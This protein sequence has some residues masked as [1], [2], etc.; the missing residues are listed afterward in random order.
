M[1]VQHR[2]GKVPIL[3][4]KWTI[5]GRYIS[6]DLHEHKVKLINDNARRLGL[7][8]IKTQTMDSQAMLREQFRT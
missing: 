5:L 6:L 8:N 1:L 3:P 4:K 7:A 2:V